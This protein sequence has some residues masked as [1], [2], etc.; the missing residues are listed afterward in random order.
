MIFSSQFIGDR[1]D[2]CA[3]N[4]FGNPLIPGGICEQCLCNG[5][6]DPDMPGSC[7][8]NSG[9]CLKCLFNTEGFNCERCKH[10]YYGDATQ[11]SCLGK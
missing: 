7:D 9:Q 8:P 10:G 5:N 6:I 3:D 1:C 4:Y 2:E 11:H